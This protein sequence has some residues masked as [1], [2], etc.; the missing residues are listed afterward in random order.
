MDARQMRA[1]APLPA[2][3]LST[4]GDVEMQPWGK[5]AGVNNGTPS[6]LRLGVFDASAP[7][8]STTPTSASHDLVNDLLNENAR[9]KRQLE[10]MSH[11]G[12]APA[13]PR[14]ANG[15]VLTGLSSTDRAANV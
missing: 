13:Q 11:G 4:P 15:P 2:V 10:E 8:V 3:K 14:I 5:H 12:V 7:T 1:T 6:A 9:L